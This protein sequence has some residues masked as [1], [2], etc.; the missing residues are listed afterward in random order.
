MSINAKFYDNRNGKISQ[1]SVNAGQ[2]SLIEIVEGNDAWRSGINMGS[3]SITV[4]FS[5]GKK[6][7]DV[8]C[9]NEQLPS[10]ARFQCL[11][12]TISLYYWKRI[13]SKTGSTTYM[14]D[15]S[16]YLEAR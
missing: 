9:A 1:V 4:V 11:Q 13:D 8:H 6:K 15:N 7:T 14:I 10:T 2:T 3:D 12:D 5:D 16:D